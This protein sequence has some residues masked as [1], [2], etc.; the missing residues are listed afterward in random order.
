MTKYKAGEYLF[1]RGRNPERPLSTRQYARL[2]SKWVGGIGL[3]PSKFATHSFTSRQGDVDLS[4][5]R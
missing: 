2:V 5:D 4:P 1:P 3:D